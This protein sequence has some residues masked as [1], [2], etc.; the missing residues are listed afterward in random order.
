MVVNY[1]RVNAVI[2]TESHEHLFVSVT[3]RRVR[4]SCKR[5]RN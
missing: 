1:F 3:G 4:V 2:I 5:L